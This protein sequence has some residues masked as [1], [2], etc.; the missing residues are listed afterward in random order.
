MG[1]PW[2]EILEIRNQYSDVEYVPGEDELSE[3]SCNQLI[4]YPEEVVPF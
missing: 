2:K 4:D 1:F 3:A